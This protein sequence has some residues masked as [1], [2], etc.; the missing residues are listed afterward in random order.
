MFFTKIGTLLAYIGMVLGVLRVASGIFIA[1]GALSNEINISAAKRYL[2]TSTTGEAI[3]GGLVL[4]ALSVA[5]G[6]LCEISRS[7]KAHRGV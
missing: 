4:I 3:D 6:I 1:S 5:L 7:C 2:G